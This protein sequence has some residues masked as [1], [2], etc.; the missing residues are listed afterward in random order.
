MR[1]GI[2]WIFSSGVRDAGRFRAVRA[3]IEDIGIRGPTRVLL[4]GA[5]ALEGEIGAGN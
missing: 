5:S 4:S 2:F 3:V 1:R